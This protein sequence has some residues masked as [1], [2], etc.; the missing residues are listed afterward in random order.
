MA[1]E[2][3]APEK[4]RSSNAGRVPREDTVIRTHID[5]RRNII[6]S[7]PES[8]DPTHMSSRS[9]SKFRSPLSA[10]RK[11]WRCS[12]ARIVA[13]EIYRLPFRIQVILRNKRRGFEVGIPAPLCPFQAS[14]PE[15]RDFL[16]ACNAGMQELATENRWMGPAEFQIAGRGFRLGAKWSFDRYDI[17]TE[18]ADES[19]LSQVSPGGTRFLALRARDGK[20]IICR[21]IPSTPPKPVFEADRLEVEIP[22]DMMGTVAFE[23]LAEFW[24]SC[25]T[26]LPEILELFRRAPHLCSE[27]K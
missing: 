20:T 16:L 17:Q 6:S 19:R 9:K 13:G 1:L 7:A 26:H 5:L 18:S 10:L 25:N 24:V 8:G 15:D 27:G 12:I 22:L 2:A 11:A 21:E 4:G 3:V 14:F 23:R